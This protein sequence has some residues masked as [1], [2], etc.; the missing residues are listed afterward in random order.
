MTGFSFGSY[1]PGTSVIH[2]LDARCKF[3][4]CIAF[5]VLLL[6]LHSPYALCA[7]AI[8]VVACYAAARIPLSLAVKSLAPLAVIV[9]VVAALNLFAVQS[10]NTLFELGFV[11]ISEGGIASATLIGSRLLIMMAATSLLTLC[12]T[13]NNITECIKCLLSPFA[14]FGLPAAEIATIMGIALRFMPQF[15]SEF[16]H[17]KNA[18][19][20]RGASLNAHAFSLR[21]L[22]ALF[23][24]LF[25]SAF[26]HANTLSAAMDARCY[27][28]PTSKYTR[29]HPLKFHV[30]DAVAACVFVVFVAVAIGI[31]V[32]I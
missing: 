15:A 6:F 23:V 16:V 29:L 1:C 14:R 19:V 8:F 22:V 12:T 24:P 30:R 11:R 9:L 31:E 20:A 4:C 17:I 2:A 10:G 27:N 13:T 3:L 32:S 5:I 26:R 21:R 28:N 7:C 25:A 18:Q